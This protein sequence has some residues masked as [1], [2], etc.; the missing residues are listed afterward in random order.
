MIRY[1]FAITFLFVAQVSAAASTQVFSDQIAFAQSVGDL[2]IEDFDSLP[3]N[4]TLS[5]G[6]FVGFDIT[7]FDIPGSPPTTTPISVFNPVAFGFFN[8]N[9][10]PNTLSR[11]LGVSG[12]DDSVPDT[13]RVIFD[14]PVAAAGLFIG[15]VGPGFTTVEMFD[16]NGGAISQ[17]SLSIGS[18][19][20]I[21]FGSGFDNRIFHGVAS[22]GLIASI[23]IVNLGFDG[24]A[25]FLDDL[26]FVTAVVPEPGSCALAVFACVGLVFRSRVIQR[27]AICRDGHR[28]GRDEFVR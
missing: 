15:N 22:G 20:V 19:G 12:F 25:I 3:T 16:Q 18:P 4:S 6:E 27:R 23:E 28:T 7:P 2:T 24:D 17:V 11:S 5:G 9:S 10:F 8:A 13:F 14:N 1:A 26:Q 21:G